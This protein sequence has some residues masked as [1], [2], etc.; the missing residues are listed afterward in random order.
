MGGKNANESSRMGFKKT[1]K[2]TG[3]CHVFRGG[4][5]AYL[6]E[7]LCLE[8]GGRDSGEGDGWHDEG[9]RHHR[10]DTAVVTVERVDGGAGATG[11]VAGGG[12]GAAGDD[13]RDDQRRG[14]DFTAAA[15]GHRHEAAL[16]GGELPGGD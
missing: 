9:G 16:E 15:A 4:R 10:L 2:G 13:A 8:V 3:G 5:N 7:G 1:R 6:G 11:A 12:G 14:L